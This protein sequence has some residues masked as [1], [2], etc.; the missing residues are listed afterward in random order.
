MTNK[1]MMMAQIHIELKDEVEH[2]HLSLEH[3]GASKTP[4]VLRVFTALYTINLA[5]GVR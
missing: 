3:L 2:V 4:R 5:R 1:A